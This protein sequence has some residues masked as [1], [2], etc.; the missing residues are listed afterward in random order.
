MREIYW[1]V[2]AFLE[3][4]NEGKQFSPTWLRVVTNDK[5]VATVTPID[6]GRINFS[7][8]FR[9]SSHGMFIVV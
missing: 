5:N 4:T 9:A 1:S 3:R 7:A 6:I 8:N 2:L